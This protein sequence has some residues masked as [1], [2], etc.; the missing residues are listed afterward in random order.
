[1]SYDEILNQVKSYPISQI[2][3]HYISLKKVGA[4]HKGICPFHSDSDP[5]LTV[6]DAKGIFKCFACNAAGN[7]ITFV[8]KY[9]NLNFIEALKEICQFLQIPTDSLDRK[10]KKDPKFEMA[11]RVLNLSAKIYRKCATSK[12]FEAYETFFKE[13]EL[14]A[15][16]AEKFMLGF[17][18]ANNVIAEYLQSQV[19]E[20][21]RPLALKTAMDIGIIKEIKG[22]LV[23]KFHERIMFPIWDQYGNVVGFTSRMT[24]PEQKAKYMNSDES[25]VFNK[26]QLL[27]PLHMA[28]NHI[29][30]DGHAIIVEG[31][32]DAIA[33]HKAGFS[34]T[35]AS[36]G[37]AFTD[38]QI[39]LVKTLTRDIYLCFDN[40]KSGFEANRKA[41]DAFMR[42]GILPKYINLSPSKDADEFLK[43]EGNL[44]EMQNRIKSAPHFIDVYVDSLIPDPIP[45]S[46]QG[47]KQILD[48]I[49]EALMPLGN[50][51]DAFERIGIAT[52]KLQIF[53]DSTHIIKAFEEFLKT[54]KTDK[55]ANKDLIQKLESEEQKSVA[56]VVPNN[57]KKPLRK[58][59]IALIKEVL[60]HPQITSDESVETMLDFITHSEV[61]QMVR[62]LKNIYYEIGEEDYIDTV[63]NLCDREGFSIELKEIVGSTLF[64]YQPMKIDEK[65]IKKLVL[66]LETKIREEHFKDKRSNLINEAK[67]TMNPNDKTKIMEQIVLIDK[68]LLNLKKANFGSLK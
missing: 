67:Q 21:D 5:S 3:S 31:N 35:V 61:K 20:S 11:H 15:E 10:E 27:Y 54:K 8:E 58:A 9:K 60:L 19:P 59:E 49:F 32:M 4:N 25:F 34:Q 28:R 29:R 68:E 38:K 18:P 45:A 26:S 14:T 37:T 44:I 62:T 2:I 33:L 66:D 64:N 42:E 41:N 51:L 12:K 46:A 30:S 22:R 52:K 6:N 39:G 48:K 1:M 47:K 36:M 63:Q 56:R 57:E 24:K 65:Q 50:S 55:T 53:T 43:I 23:D 17:A 16:I 7:S 40:D 13:R